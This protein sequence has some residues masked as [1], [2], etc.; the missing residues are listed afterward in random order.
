MSIEVPHGWVGV[1]FFQR[2]VSAGLCTFREAYRPTFD[3]DKFFS[4][5]RFLDFE[6]YLRKKAAAQASGKGNSMLLDD[7]IASEK[8]ARGMK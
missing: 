3:F 8:Q 7:F 5:H 2:I 6:E 1:N 4:M